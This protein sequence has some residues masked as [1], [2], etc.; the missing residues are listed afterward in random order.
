MRKTD[1]INSEDLFFCSEY[2][3][4]AAIL[5]GALRAGIKKDIFSTY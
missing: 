5:I 2:L 1:L 3:V 4:Y